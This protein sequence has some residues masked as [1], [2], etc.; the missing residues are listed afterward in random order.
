M[1]GRIN[2][3]DIEALRERAD[4][5]AVVGD[6]TGLKRVGS[7]LKGLC[8][9]HQEKTPSFHIDPG[10][11]LFHCFGCGEGGDVFA[12]LQKIEALTFPESVER[13]A[14]MVGYELRY[15]ALSPGQRQAL[16]R[17]TRLAQAL[18]EAAT[19]FQSCLA[20]EE[21]ERARA[22]A[23]ER[24]LTQE[25][26]AYFGLGWAPDR[27][28]GLVRH[29]VGSFEVD[30]L[31]EA[32]LAVQGRHGPIDRFRGR[33]MFP[34]YDK[35]GK[36]V[37]AFGGRVLP[38]FPPS[39]GSR[40]G[41][42]PKYVNSPESPVYRKA[43][44]LYALNWA[45]AEM[46]RRDTA[47]VVEG[48]TDVIG[49]HLAGVRHA[50]ATCGTALTT[51]H[52]RLL[53]KFARRVV[54]A[55]DADDAGY[56][57]ADRARS[58]AGEAGL[59]EVGVLALPPGQDPAD[60]AA[61]GAEAVEAALEGTQTAVEFQISQLLRTADTDTP[62]AQV[63]AYHRVF[64]LLARL[65]DRFLRYRYI[66]D[67]VAPATR[68]S[69]DR[70]EEEL[71]AELAREQDTDPR[72]APGGA[73]GAAPPEPG[74]AETAGVSAGLPGGPGDVAGGQALDPQMWLE[75]QVL[76]AALQSPDLL[77]GSWKHVTADDFRAPMSQQLFRALSQAATSELDAV[78]AAL[79][80][81]QLRG[82]VRA[83][84]VAEPEVD[85]EPG[86]LAS[87]V[88]DLRAATLQRE[89]ETTRQDLTS[90]NRTTDPQ[91]HRELITRIADL[92]R[93]R[94]EILEGRE[95]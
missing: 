50:V 84:A 11:G 58:L 85:A 19:Y 9:L 29:L 8:P 94:R 65:P 5:A 73:A 34:I 95:T 6:Y 25:D 78:L 92:D 45:R 67:L 3:D 76:Q 71:D 64:P 38:D 37:I 26:V 79:P 46:Q 82:R 59:R 20:S 13:L 14:R 39:T 33:L 80:D 77:P 75:R 27:W 23:A 7:R 18:A 42:V 70:I 81:E 35:S 91:R 4:L 56:A 12:F 72:G 32:G 51:D 30:E 88:A 2:D 41:D 66:R 74:P 93:R 86:K 44:T 52:F 15:E 21:G 62:E 53:E 54:I 40:D 10:R 90:V 61:E 69:A 49:L 60:L 55:L 47:L 28:D 24:G 17:R 89:R 83:L 43:E 57:A 48:Y 87:L 1:P 63:D 16:G 31:V 22:Y 36:D 68:L